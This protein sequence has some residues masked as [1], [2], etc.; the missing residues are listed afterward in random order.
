MKEQ[1]AKTDFYEVAVDK[2]KNRFYLM[3]KGRW[4][5]TAQV[6]KYLADVDKGIRQM[7]RGF[8]TL[9]ELTQMEPPSPEVASLH[10]GVQKRVLALGGSKTAEVVPPEALTRAVLDKMRSESKLSTRQFGST[11]EAEAWLD[12]P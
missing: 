12:E 3:I 9:A 2:A 4:E 1:T 7:S 11:A 5:R 10:E 6:P 8:T